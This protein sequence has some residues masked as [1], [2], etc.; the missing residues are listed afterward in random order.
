MYGSLTDTYIGVKEKMH[1]T[2]SHAK[3]GTRSRA[4]FACGQYP[5]LLHIKKSSAQDNPSRK[6]K[7]SKSIKCFEVWFQDQHET[8]L[9]SNVNNKSGT[10]KL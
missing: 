3:E 4:G 10:F 5:G 6:E 9:G 8:H 1:I 2:G 7:E